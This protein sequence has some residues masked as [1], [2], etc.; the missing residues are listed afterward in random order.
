M[1]G[2]VVSEQNL[3]FGQ[4]FNISIKADIIFLFELMLKINYFS[5]VEANSIQEIDIHF[6]SIL[7]LIGFNIDIYMTYPLGILNLF[8]LA[9]WFLLASFFS[10]YTKKSFWT[11]LGFVAKTY[12]IGLLLWILFIMFIILNLFVTIQL[13]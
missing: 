6:L 3:K 4:C 1:T 7:Q 10:N 9:Y 2:V 12:G 5:I 8:E 13:L 11:S